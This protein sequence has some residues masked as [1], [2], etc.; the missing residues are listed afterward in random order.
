VKNPD[1]KKVA[2]SDGGGVGRAAT[3]PVAERSNGNG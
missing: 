2:A 3:N 1:L